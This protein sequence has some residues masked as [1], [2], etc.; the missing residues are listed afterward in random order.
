MFFNEITKFEYNEIYFR[1]QQLILICRRFLPKEYN[2]CS[3]K[4]V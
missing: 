1:T 2:Q 4:A 3:E